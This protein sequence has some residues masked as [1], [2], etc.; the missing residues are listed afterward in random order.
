MAVAALTRLARL[1]AV[2]VTLL[3]TGPGIAQEDEHGGG[4][5]ANGVRQPTGTAEFGLGWLV[6]PGTRVC[7]KVGCRLGDSSLALEG[8]QV[9]RAGPRLAAGAGLLLGLTPTTDAPRQ[10]PAGITR[11]HYRSY[12]T[13]ETG[14]RY[15]PY[16]GDALEAWVG[17]TMGLVV[18][19]D[20]FSTHATTEDNR[21]LVGPRGITIRTEGFALG[22]G[23]GAAYEFAPH[24][25]AGASLRYA[26]WFLPNTPATDAFGDEASLVGRNSVFVVGLDL[27]YR[28]SL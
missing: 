5:L 25:L 26:S 12:L 3:R 8:W 1:A 28:L 2:G 10:D 19:G 16:V 13:V 24:W 27:A 21:A 11:D 9:L 18:V 15:Y 20:K 17:I 4:T 6:L 23:G 22:A 7:Q 14:A